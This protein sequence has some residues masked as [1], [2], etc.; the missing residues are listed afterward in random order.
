[1]G[2]KGTSP[3]SVG[4]RELK[5]HLSSY[6]RRAKE[7]ETVEI[8]DRGRVVAE[9][10]PR[11]ALSVSEIEERISELA[12]QG[13]VRP[14]ASSDTSFLRKWKGLGLSRKQIEAFWRDFQWSREDKF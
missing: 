1:M 12:R 13:R 3:R 8:T 6:L 10:G 14:A 4:V 5:A 9:L 2:R 7:G 11:R